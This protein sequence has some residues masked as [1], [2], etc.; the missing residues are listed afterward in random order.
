MNLFIQAA[1]ASI[2]PISELRGG[3]LLAIAQGAN[4]FAA[5]VISVLSN[6]FVAPLVFIFLDFI[7]HKLLAIR[8]YK[9]SFN[10]IVE[11]AR[12]KS[13]PFVTNYGMLGLTLFVAI[14]LPMTGAYT[15]SLAAWFFGMNRLKA[16]L[17]ISLGVI[18]AGLIV[19]TAVYPVYAIFSSSKVPLV[20]R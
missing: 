13:K 11:G 9:K 2:L 15:A 1:I 3:M 8:L 10:R 20:C 14:P 7:H 12:R 16:I 6:L 17:A 5:F 18:V 4:P 19:L